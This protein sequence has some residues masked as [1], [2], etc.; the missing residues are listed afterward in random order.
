[1][2]LEENEEENNNENKLKK[3]DALPE[4]AASI[5]SSLPEGMKT[6]VSPLS[7][8]NMLE[9]SR[10]ITGLESVVM[11]NPAQIAGALKINE[12]MAETL[13]MVS[14]CT[15]SI[16]AANMASGVLE[17]INA[18]GKMSD[19]LK[20]QLNMTQILQ[21]TQTAAKLIAGCS[22]LFSKQWVNAVN[23]IQKLDA[24]SLAAMRLLPQYRNEKLPR[25]SKQVMKAL[26]K[27]AAKELA[28]T[29]D[30]IVDPKDGTFYHEDAP[31]QKITANQITVVESSLE[32]F[33]TIGFDELVSFE[34]KLLREPDFAIW[35]PIGQ[36]IYQIIEKW[37]IFISFKDIT[38]YHAR[39]HDTG[40]QPFT[41]EEMLKAPT[42][43]SSHGRYNR[44]GRSCYYIAETKEGAINEIRKHGGGTKPEIQ[45]VGIRA[46]K[47]AKIIDLSGRP[48][49]SNEF[50][51]HLR[52]SVDN[53]EGKIVYQYLLPNFVAACCKKLGIEG[54]RYKSSKSQ[55]YNCIVLWKDD[56]FEFVD[57]SR[58]IIVTD[59]DK[60]D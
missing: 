55:D 2:S 29:K 41:D 22:E 58:K 54:I 43:V 45:I 31:E 35:D 34:T 11:P 15:N 53:E 18:T 19:L 42:N 39:K 50:I 30:I 17:T 5:I 52:Y 32:L 24:P 57:G 33:E 1:M 37:N 25:G 10:K 7:Y 8:S 46:V 12:S 48:G 38:Y 21:N 49:K 4:I 6:A 59:R 44:I 13:K 3:D 36:K 27:N 14:M 40:K 56:Y 23:G 51:E 20:Y 60:E 26:T 47:E 28:K 9:A 16:T